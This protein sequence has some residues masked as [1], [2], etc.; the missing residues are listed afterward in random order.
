MYQDQYPHSLTLD[1][2][3]ARVRALTDYWAAKHGV[4]FDCKENTAQVAGK[5]LGISFKASFEITEDRI[6]GQI[7]VTTL[8]EKLGGRRYLEGKLAEYLDPANPLEEL[9]ARI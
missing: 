4:H 9:L 6:L 1:Q 2:A 3:L 7:E 5:V 8:T